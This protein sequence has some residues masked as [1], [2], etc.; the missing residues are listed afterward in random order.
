L[1]RY[2]KNEL[3]KEFGIFT[4]KVILSVGAINRGHK[5]MDYL[6]N[7]VAKLSEEWTLVV[8]GAARGNEG[9][10][11][12]NLG[13]E[14]MGNRFIHLF[15]DRE[16]ISK[17]YAV[18]DIFVLAS[19]QEGFGIVILEAMQSG[20]PVLLHDRELFRWILNQPDCCINM[21]KKGCLSDIL[22]K[23]SSDGEWIKRKSVLNKKIFS[24]NYSW[25]GLRKQYLSLLIGKNK[26][27]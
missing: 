19:T 4:P 7:E 18:A 9:D 16:E 5:R 14:K 1:P 27:E 23:C 22:I 21:E 17:V 13:K 20:L 12:L 10:I 25:Q 6:I 2:N 11:V 15:M 3:R 24:E 26:F 8:C